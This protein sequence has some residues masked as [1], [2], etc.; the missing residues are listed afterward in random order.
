MFNNMYAHPGSQMIQT[1]S[2]QATWH[3]TSTVLINHT[4]LSSLKKYF[5]SII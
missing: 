5:F 4:S 2:V 1:E 3:T